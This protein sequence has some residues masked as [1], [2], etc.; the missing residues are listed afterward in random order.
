MTSLCRRAPLVLALALTALASHGPAAAQG[1][2]GACPSD[3]LGT[4]RTLTLKREYA[5]YGTVGHA[6]L[7]LA[8]GEVVLTF[9]DGPRP[10]TVN[11]VL[12]ALADQCVRA[13]FFM[14]GQN[15]VAHPELGPL[16]ASRGHATGSHS[17]SHPQLGQMTPEA[18][19]KDLE[20]GIQAYVAAFG[21]TPPAYRFP[22][23]GETPTVL[24]ALKAK[25][26]TVMS[27]DTG[28]DDWAPN[29]QRTDVMVR[30]LLDNLKA[31]GGGIILMHDANEPTAVAL[32]AMLRAIRD[33]GYK[34]VHV[35]WEQ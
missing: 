2:A 15:L 11:R 19:L 8:K 3:R 14:V 29:D 27:V 13:T 26:I 35:R 6:P 12:D 7:P 17:F 31:K 1:A 22:F 9:D 5:E 21:S 30:R 16:V 4:S 28:I 10:E 25:R 18:Q 20:Q 23:L 24:D 34:V 33:N 32:P